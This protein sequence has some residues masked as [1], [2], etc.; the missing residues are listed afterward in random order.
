LIYYCN[1]GKKERFI[2]G[3]ILSKGH[4]QVFS[5]GENSM[6]KL[7]RVP[8][9]IGIIPD[10]NR[11][12]ASAH[13][14]PKEAGYEHGIE[15]GKELFKAGFDLGIDEVSVYTFTKENIHRPKKQIIAFQNAFLEFIEW[16]TAKNVSILLVGDVNSPYFPKKVKKY[17]KPEKDRMKK[18]RLNF[19]VN[20]SWKWDL[21]MA[22]INSSKKTVSRTNLM[23]NIGS[24]YISRVDLL[25]RWGERMRLS[26]FLPIQ[27]AYADI[28]IIDDLWPDFRV[29]QFYDALRWYEK[30]DI[31]LGG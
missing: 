22:L 14:L 8:K 24:R 15:P 5:G 13:A 25:I 17:T 19:L 9:H 31:T 30:Q 10:G 11:R 20:Y 3:F 29:E 18:K 23:D 12:W 21:S 2:N 7:K 27:C 4:K 1:S 26:G 16:I 6:L 28:Y